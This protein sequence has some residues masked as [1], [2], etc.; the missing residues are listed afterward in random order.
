M[1]HPSCN[2]SAGE[3]SPAVAEALPSVVSDAKLQNNRSARH[4]VQWSHPLVYTRGVPS[5]GPQGVNPT[6]PTVASSA[7]LNHSSQRGSR[8]ITSGMENLNL[9]STVSSLTGMSQAI[10]EGISIPR[11]PN[12]R[13]IFLRRLQAAQARELNSTVIDGSLATTEPQSLIPV[14]VSEAVLNP[15]NGTVESTNVNGNPPPT[16]T[17]MGDVIDLTHGSD[18]E[19]SLLQKQPK[20]EKSTQRQTNTQILS[21]PIKVNTA[22]R[23]LDSESSDASDGGP[24]KRSK[25]KEAPRPP[26]DSDS[27]TSDV[28]HISPGP[29]SSIE[30]TS[31]S[32]RLSSSSV[33]VADDVIP[34]GPRSIADVY[35]NRAESSTSLNDT[36]APRHSA[37]GSGVSVV[38]RTHRRPALGGSAVASSSRIRVED[39]EVETGDPQRA[40]LYASAISRKVRMWA[41]K[42]KGI[43]RAHLDSLFDDDVKIMSKGE[44]LKL[45]RDIDEDKNWATRAEVE[46]TRL[47]RFLIA[48][49]TEHLVDGTEA[50]KLAM[51]ILD[52]F[53][54]RFRGERYPQTRR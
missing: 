36:Q 26:L 15:P 37:R 40:R 21:T 4:H 41:E 50:H 12:L 14:V 27:A 30:P 28:D 18:E 52:N 2:S 51:R 9:T 49:V 20:I 29:C 42:L 38:V 5:R 23:R 11:D 53:A 34:D 32:D 45:L 39:M 19:N 22:K 35:N 6:L 25:R 1:A 17:V 48:V 43:P 24:T 13:F 16:S 47:E 10:P 54:Q 46:D 7:I 3:S 44:I 8:I 31:S 33:E